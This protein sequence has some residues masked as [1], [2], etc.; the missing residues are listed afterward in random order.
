MTEDEAKATLKKEGYTHIFTWFDSPEEYYTPHTHPE[1]RDHIIIQGEATIDMN[2]ES[3]VYRV[4]DRFL[5]PANVSHAAT[6][7]PEGSTYVF[8]KK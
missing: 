8:G 3:H 1:D 5:L 7:G 6:I 4:G 2:G